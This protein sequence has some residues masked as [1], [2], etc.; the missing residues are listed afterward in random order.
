MW[1]HYDDKPAA[2][3]AL[4]ARG[5]RQISNYSWLSADNTVRA[6]LHP[7]LGANWVACYSE[8]D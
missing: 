5:F 1:I 2:V 3:A 8:N 6:T 4:T 7:T